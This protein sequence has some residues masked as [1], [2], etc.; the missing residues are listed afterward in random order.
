MIAEPFPS[1]WHSLGDDKSALDY[2][3]ID[4]INKVLT[5]LQR[6]FHLRIPRKGTARPQSQFPHIVSVTDLYIPSTGPHIFLQQ[7][8][9]TD[10]G[11]IYKSLTDTW[12]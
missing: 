9:Q 1:V 4:Y 5:P 2:P 8:K 10:G 3:T 11:N 7:N 6:K 12:M